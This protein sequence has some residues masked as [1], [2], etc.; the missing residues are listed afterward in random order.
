MAL[1]F[2]S[3]MKKNHF[4]YQ[5][6]D[7]Q[8][9]TSPKE[10]NFVM[11]NLF[12]T[13]ILA[14]ILSFS[15][16]EQ[17]ALATT[18]IGSQ[19]LEFV[20]ISEQEIFIPAKTTKNT[21]QAQDIFYNSFIHNSNDPVLRIAI[22][23]LVKETLGTPPFP[24]ISATI[25]LEAK[26]L[27]SIETL[28]GE[29][30]VNTEVIRPFNA[31]FYTCEVPDRKNTGSIVLEN[32]AKTLST[33]LPTNEGLSKAFEDIQSEVKEARTTHAQVTKDC[34]IRFANNNCTIT[35]NRQLSHIDFPSFK[36]SLK[37]DSCDSDFLD[38]DIT[39]S[40]KTLEN[41][42]LIAITE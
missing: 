40:V 2:F 20:N 22:R 33:E 18:L 24:I 7:I 23:L 41:G 17:E 34:A 39:A 38:N 19:S 3:S 16:F 1:V 12:S 15:F 42:V 25:D 11:R 31:T 9:N 37:Q 14:L 29:E 8:V 26:P 36:L 28:L 32:L 30:L 5:S 13:L 21:K 10:G 27:I 35:I 6:I 4:T